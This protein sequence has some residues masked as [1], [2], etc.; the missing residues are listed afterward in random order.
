VALRRGFKTDAN[1]LAREV[2]RELGLA[3]HAPLCPRALAEHLAIPIM[4][5]DEFRDA[6]PEAVACLQSQGNRF[7]LSAVTI[8]F[9]YRR[10]IIHNN[11]H[12]PKRQASNLIHE[13]SHGLLMHP[14]K[15]PFDANG[16]RHYDDELEEEAN[17]LG[18]AL[19]ISAEAALHIAEQGHS[20][21]VASDLYGATVD[22]VRMRLNVSG[23][24]KRVAYRARTQ[25]R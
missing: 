1:R 12:S 6:V 5:L 14:P 13:L 9:G 23:A 15:P 11:S 18:P 7:A 3:D 22:V 17:W 20:V 25:A 8:F 19:L 10:V 21:G 16:S 24:T 2:R 4:T